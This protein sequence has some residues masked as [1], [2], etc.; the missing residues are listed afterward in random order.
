MI[1]KRTMVISIVLVSALLGAL[2]CQS[3]VAQKEKS[4]QQIVNRDSF[5]NRGQGRVQIMEPIVAGKFYPAEPAQLTKMVDGFLNKAGQQKIEQDIFGLIA[6]HAGYVYSGPVAGYAYRPLIGLKYDLIVVLGPSHHTQRPDVAILDIDQYR[7][8]LGTIRIDR[9]AVKALMSGADPLSSDD[10]PFRVEHSLEVQLP[11]LQKVLPGVPMVMIAI[12]RPEHDVC[13]K[14]AHKLDAVLQNRRALIVA[15]SDLSHYHPYETA[16]QMDQKTLALIQQMEIEKLAHQLLN[17]KL[18]ACG[19]GPILTL[20]EF[21]KLRQGKEIRLAK[22]LNSGDTAGGKDRV[23]GYGAVHFL[24]GQQGRG[25]MTE[26][27]LSEEDKK[28]LLKI[29]RQTVES[30]VKTGKRP[31]VDIDSDALQKDGAAF[32]TLRKK[33]DL[34]GCIGHV[35]AREPLYLS[36]QNMA[37]AA[38]SEDPR[39]PPVKEKELTDIDIEVSVLT[40]MQVVE[41]PTTIQV[42]RDGLMISKGGR[43]GLL[44]PQVPD[45][46]GWD[47]ETF[48]DQTC[49]KAGLPFG[50]W[51]EPD[52]QILSFQA[53]V[54]Q[55]N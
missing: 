10:S 33:G 19:T 36:V 42:G 31:D 44:L 13:R 4:R 45:E 1:I 38:S 2:S 29:A 5:L 39:F 21:F 26:S 46:Y 43:Q 17:R 53:I 52:T 40:P 37:V 41:D 32:V 16:Q 28:V 47:R 20:M 8:P 30:F 55:E 7:T 35:I 14:L 24:G 3:E 54:F 15:S 27:Y 6:P 18:E 11:F 34:R 50:A 23:V 22:Y 9:P 25:P 51:K 12:A 49:R 48:L